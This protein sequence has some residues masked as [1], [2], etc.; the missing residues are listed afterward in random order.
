MPERSY[1]WP[2]GPWDW[3]Q[4]LAFK[5]G[6]R[7]GEGVCRPQSA[8][9]RESMR[10]TIGRSVCFSYALMLLIGVFCE[11][12]SAENQTTIART[13]ENFTLGMG[14]EQAFTLFAS[15]VKQH[16][17]TILG[18]NALLLD[19][20]ESLKDKWI[21]PAHTDP[22]RFY[23][24]GFTEPEFNKSKRVNRKLL[25]QLE[26]T[27]AFKSNTTTSI[28]LSF[29]KSMLFKIDV[30]PAFQYD[31]VHKMLRKMYG[32]PS[33]FI[34]IRQY[35]TSIEVEQWSDNKTMIKLMR[36]NHDY[37]NY[38]RIF[39]IDRHLYALL[40]NKAAAIK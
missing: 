14:K 16:N 35:N 19:P 15:G 11:R 28:I 5:H 31:I 37:R 10:T 27:L 3:Y 20:V 40:K 38:S 29:Y 7:A 39:Y 13:I 34:K 33:K 25:K 18:S 32:H 21:T 9:R 8:E 24:E 17:F 26:E 23:M 12:G 36:N 1:A 4:H 2:E 30:A 22:A 6:L